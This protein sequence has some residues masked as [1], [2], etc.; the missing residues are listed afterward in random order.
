MPQRIFLGRQQL[1]ADAVVGR[2]CTLIPTESPMTDFG[3]IA[4]VL[5]G[6]AARR[7]VQRRLAEK[8]GALLP[9]EFL[10]PSQLLRYGAETGCLASPMETELIWQRALCRALETPE[11]FALLFPGGTV[12]LPR[13]PGKLFARLREELTRGGIS[14]SDAADALGSRG[15]ELAGLE[16]LFL[17]EAEKCG[18][19]DPLQLDLK[20]AG[21]VAPLENFDRIILAGVPDLPHMLKKRLENLCAVRPDIL[22]IWL[23]APES[24]STA[25]DDYGVPLAEVW[26]ERALPLDPAAVEVALDDRDAAVRAR[27]FA[28]GSGER[29]DPEE[30]AVALAD[31]ELE[32]SFVEIFSEIGSA[33]EHLL[34][35][36]PSTGVPAKKLRLARLGAALVDFLKNRDDFAAGA[37]LLAERDFLAAC[38]AEKGNENQILAA[39]DDFRQTCYPDDFEAACIFLREISSRSKF[40]QILLPL[41]EKIADLPRQLEQSESAAVFLKDFFNSVFRRE[42]DRNEKSF[43]I[44]LGDEIDL[45][46]RKI[47]EFCALPPELAKGT[48]KLAEL[49]LFFQ[50][51]EQEMLPVSRG[52]LVLEGMLEIPFFT[53]R[54]VILVG[55]NEKFYPDRIAPTAFLTDSIRQKLHLRHNGDTFARAMCHLRSLLDPRK[56]E[57]VKFFVLKNSSQKEVL[58]PSPLFFS[59]A[60]DEKELLSRTRKFFSPVSARET[61]QGASQEEKRFTFDWQSDGIPFFR[62]APVLAVTAFKNYLAGA[63]RFF[64]ANVLRAEPTDYTLAEPD[65]SGF[66][67][68]CHAAFEPL[69]K[70]SCTGEEEFYRALERNLRRF[71]RENFGERLPVLI[72]LQQE[73]LLQRFQYA[74]RLLEAERR[75]GFVLLETE[76]RFG[77]GMP[78]PLGEGFV[79]GTADR[80]EY[81]AAS[82]TLRILDIKTGKIES[83]EKEH[84]QAGKFINLQLPLYAI[85]LRRDSEFARRHPDIDLANV[86]IEC[87][88]FLLPRAVTES[89]ID[90][91]QRE[92]FDAVLDAAQ[93]CAERVLAEVTEMKNK[94]FFGEADNNALPDALK[95][96]V[97]DFAAAFPGVSWQERADDDEK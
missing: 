90:L 85:L 70:I 61:E 7:A 16:K 3:R 37:A 69:Q 72:Q 19:D 14:I 68:I 77:G 59:G 18:F 22:E 21:C 87:G 11:R 81:R 94:I 42:F 89:R 6:M 67:S 43:G 53:S 54:R 49:E 36:T 24:E 44:P 1:L 56:R 47:G 38:A 84:C 31:P 95:Q 71:L 25:F 40:A 10:M 74:A 93:A 29:F 23:H 8:F 51:F 62:D 27:D 35:V 78:I 26:A 2:L 34:T 60:L 52:D 12:D 46:R 15:S 83:V 28:V 91:W 57:D 58:K 79:K 66:G 82:N 80:I 45:F 50:H 76:Y 88:Y 65:A 17:E 5:P 63:E 4:V 64:L 48:A 20:A 55:V 75:D 13:M 30:C 97:P 32:T 73:N 33:T 92:K 86:A 96:I 9:P 39:L 41:L